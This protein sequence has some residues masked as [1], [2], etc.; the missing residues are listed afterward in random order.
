MA[1]PQRLNRKSRLAFG[2]GRWQNHF[3]VVPTQRARPI[4]TS[5][6]LGGDGD[7][8]LQG[9]PGLDVLDGGLGSNV[10]LQD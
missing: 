1:F 10:L 8:V 6:L 3:L 2:L 4:I 5:L 9:G 7:D